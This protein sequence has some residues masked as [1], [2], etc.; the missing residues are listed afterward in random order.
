[1]TEAREWT[2]AGPLVAGINAFGFGGTNA[3]AVLEEAPRHVTDVVDAPYVDAPYSDVSYGSASGGAARLLTLSARSTEGLRAAA[4]RLAAHLDRHPELDEGDVCL[5]ASTSR[6]DGPHRLAVVAE[7][8]LAARLATA[9][10]LGGVVARSRPRVVFLFP[11]QGAQLPGRDRVL[12][13][14]APLFRDTLDEA[15]ALL[16]P[17]RGGPWWSGPS[18]RRSTPPTRPSPRWRSR[19]SSPPG[20]RSPASCASGVWSPT[21]WPVTVSG[22]SPLPAWAEC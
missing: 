3:H 12:Y 22:R 19:C 1:M 10:P 6:D 15:S 13:R 8:D 16:G 14:T 17:V 11:G 9:A 2:S 20:S 5:T 21:R 18:T 7:G 4:G